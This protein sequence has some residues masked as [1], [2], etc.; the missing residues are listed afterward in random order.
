MCFV[1]QRVERFH[2]AARQRDE[3]FTRDARFLE[4]ELRA[5]WLTLVV[6]PPCGEEPQ[7]KRGGNGGRI[8]DE[9]A[10][11]GHRA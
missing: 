1:V 9:P 8:N 3:G 7:I 6:Q 5:K 2:V 11:C 4:I 10:D